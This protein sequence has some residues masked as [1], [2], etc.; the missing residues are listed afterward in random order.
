MERGLAALAS[1]GIDGL[2]RRTSCESAKRVG[3]AESTLAPVRDEILGRESES[4]GADPDALM[5]V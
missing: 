3:N 1:Q 2:E 4:I 5:T